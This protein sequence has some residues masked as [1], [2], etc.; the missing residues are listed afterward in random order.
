MVKYI[1]I[2]KGYDYK[3][4]L[5]GYITF[6]NTLNKSLFS[7]PH[8]LWGR[9]NVL[10]YK[11]RNIVTHLCPHLVSLDFTIFLEK[12]FY[13][14]LSKC[15]CD[16][17]LPYSVPMSKY[18]IALTTMT[19]QFHNG[20]LLVAFT[21]QTPNHSQAGCSRALRRTHGV[22]VVDSRFFHLS[23]LFFFKVMNSHCMDTSLGISTYLLGFLI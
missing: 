13:S 10:V 16:F 19:I 5:M 9:L 12:N 18:I 2:S 6:L 1:L 11:F 17:R 3:D 8:F 15:Q 14:S 21:L 7:G 23:F 22:W 20:L 4:A